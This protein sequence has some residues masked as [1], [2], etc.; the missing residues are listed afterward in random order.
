MHVKISHGTYTKKKTRKI[1]VSELN[2]LKNNFSDLKNTLIVNFEKKRF[3][4][5]HTK[6]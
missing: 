4:E 6:I 5:G 3:G 1:L 2:P